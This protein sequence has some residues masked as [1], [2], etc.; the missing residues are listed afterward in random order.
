MQCTGARTTLGEARATHCQ[1]LGCSTN[2][3]S[4]GRTRASTAATNSHTS[5][6]T[7][8]PPPKPQTTAG[9][10]TGSK[11]RV[12]GEG[13]SGLRGGSPGD[14]Y[15]TVSGRPHPD[16]RR[17]GADVHSDLEVSYLDAILGSQITVPTVHGP[18]EM[19]LPTG[20]QPGATLRMRGKGAPKLRDPGNA[21]GDHFVHVKV[22]L[23]KG[24]SD[25]QRRALEGLRE[26]DVRANAA[27]RN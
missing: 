18:V 6:A 1:P 25:E 10:D 13:C 16:W 27:A 26:M 8:P 22:R 15:A 11:L 12:R 14:V 2:T 5:H 7:A 20:T 24:L 21:N 23:P 19:R 3:R 4:S 9:V 17:D